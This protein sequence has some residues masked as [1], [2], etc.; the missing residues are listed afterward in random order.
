[1]MGPETPPPLYHHAFQISTHEVDACNR[2]HLHALARC[3]QEAASQHA[4]RLGYGY[5]EMQRRG[6]FWVMVELVMEIQRLPGWP[7][8]GEVRTWIVD[9]GVLR[10]RRDMEVRGTDGSLWARAATIWALLDARTHRPLRLEKVA[11][12]DLPRFPDRRALTTPKFQWNPGNP[13]PRVWQ[14]RVR[15]SDVDLQ[16]HLNNTQHL[17][18]AMDALPPEW[19]TTHRPAFVHVRFLREAR[20]G[21]HIGVRF[22]H[23]KA[24]SSHEI[25]RIGDNRPLARLHL[26]W[27]EEDGPCIP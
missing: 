1:M 17:R 2:W 26:T 20:V 4:L 25:F 15:W 24:S 9:H 18:L 5:E 21:D 10:G 27:E 19:L 6:S 14:D 3:L 7:A 23:E 16:G 11:R 13:A 22:W 12:E 8:H